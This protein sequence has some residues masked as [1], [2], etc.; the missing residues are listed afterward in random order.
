MELEQ[1]TPGATIIPII[2]SSDKTPITLFGGKQAYPVYLTIGNIPKEIRRKPSY[3]AQILLA[4]LPTTKLDHITNLSARRRML[5]NVVHAALRQALA[6]LEEAGKSGILL[7]SGDGVERRC[8]PILAAHCGDYMEHLTIVGCKMGE[9]PHCTVPHRELG[10]YGEKYAIRSLEHILAALELYDTDPAYFLRGCEDV[11]I[12]A[13]I[14]PYWQHLPYNN[15]FLSIPPDILHQIHSG[16]IKHML[17]WIK[18][19]FSKE[20]LDER[21]RCLPLNH[22]MRHFNRGIT[23]T[24]YFTGKEHSEIAKFMLGLIVDMPLPGGR[25]QALRLIQAFQGHFLSFYDV[26]YTDLSEGLLDFCYIAQYPVQSTS[27]LTS[28]EASLERFHKYKDVFVELGVRPDFNLP[29]LHYARHYVDLIQ[30]LGTTDNYN[31]EHTERL[32][33]DFAKQAYKAT[34]H[35]DEFFQMTRWL[36]RKEKIYRHAAYIAWRV[37]GNMAF[38]LSSYYISVLTG[39]YNRMS[40]I[41]A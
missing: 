13:I 8:H 21:A 35:K 32:H 15:I 30:W 37:A 2:L 33:I 17:N 22:H 34:N 40:T 11:N 38:Y 6:P 3:H 18:E 16:L 5:A 9:C 36:E 20:E 23:H 26:Q 25:P 28:L 24:T 1:S 10:D 41:V 14:H 12:K 31:T 4:Y 19:I 29:K 27:T 39:P 7:C